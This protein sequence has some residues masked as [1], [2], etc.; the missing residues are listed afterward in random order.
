MRWLLLLMV[1][2]LAGCD[3]PDTH[4]HKQQ[5][6]VFGTL[7]EVLIWTDEEEA[8]SEAMT[9][10]NAQFQQQ[11]QQWHPW[12][13]G[14]LRAFNQQLS[15][16]DS[17]PIPDV[18]S[19]LLARSIEL[20]IASDGLFDPALGRLVELWGFSDNLV[21]ASQP[22]DAAAL[23]DF[24]E[25]APRIKDLEINSGVAQSH[26]ALLYLD[27]GGF[28]KGY[29]VDRAIE[30]LREMGF[31]NAIVNAGG[32]LRAI[33]SKGEWPWRIGIRNPRGEGLIA[34]LQIS[35]DESVFTSGDYERFYEYRGKRY[36]HIID[37]RSGY[38][39]AGFSSVTILHG[40]AATA[41]AA[42][43]ALMVAGP[44][45]WREVAKKMGL[46]HVMVITPQGDISMT[47]A[48]VERIRFE[49]SP[50]P[51]VKVVDW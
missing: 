8:A 31:E 18:I 35:G 48:M 23:A 29:A 9:R 47:P 42:A 51:L 26:N 40:D 49:V 45:Q 34:S 5:M 20:S 46:N 12:E 43:T 32:D 37:P 13:P 24:T 16:G 22:P 36:H 25:H 1:L 15:S 44:K 10:L 11:H 50:A 2:L 3:H 38:P 30:A 28:A 6:Y 21:N 7:V 39:T 14:L 4:S 27:F 19:P 41:D 17:V 33:G